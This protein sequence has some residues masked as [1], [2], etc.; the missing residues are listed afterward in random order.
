[1]E[2]QLFVTAY[3]RTLPQRNTHPELADIMQSAREWSHTFGEILH[4]H[5]SDKPIEAIEGEDLAH[6]EQGILSRYIPRWNMGTIAA[7]E[8][9]ISNTSQPTAEEKGKATQ[10]LNFL[11]LNTCMYQM[12]TPILYGNWD[13]S[14]EKTIT[15]DY[16]QDML[17][18]M[19]LNMYNHRETM[20]TTRSQSKSGEYLYF[21]PELAEWRGR[22]EGVLHEFDSAVVLLEVAR[23]IRGITIVPAPAQFEHGEQPA[24]N[25]DFVAVTQDGRAVGIQVKSGVTSEDRDHYDPERI[26]FIDA[27]VDLNSVIA[28]RTKAQQSTLKQVAWP[29]V[30]CLQ[31]TLQTETH[32][33][34]GEFA[35]HTGNAKALLVRKM[36]TRALVGNM[37]PSIHLAAKRIGERL[38]AK[39][40]EG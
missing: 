32:G 26:I 18:H 4:D 7:I 16:T 3:E 9:K 35:R 34:R 22:F 11:L 5:L 6:A 1:M 17:G 37:Q 31:R 40:Q 14:H 10:E 39:L 21:S 8:Q 30:I 13:F 36:Q 15:L 28:K 23:R 27:K 20:S 24:V 2:A 19:V 33:K 38:L 25:A 12:W 29:G